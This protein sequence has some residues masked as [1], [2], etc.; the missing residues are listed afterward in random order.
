VG[1]GSGLDHVTLFD[2]LVEEGVEAVPACA[3]G[4]DLTHEPEYRK[5]GFFADESG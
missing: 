2:L 4:I 5:S 1:V 3:E